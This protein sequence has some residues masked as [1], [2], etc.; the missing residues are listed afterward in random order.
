MIE[1]GSCVY[2]YTVQEHKKN[3]L[4]R[5]VAECFAEGKLHWSNVTHSH[6]KVSSCM[7][8]LSN[9]PLKDTLLYKLNSH[10]YF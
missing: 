7:W 9:Q 5:Q 1:E 10:S 8:S 4:E 2:P 6:I 3:I